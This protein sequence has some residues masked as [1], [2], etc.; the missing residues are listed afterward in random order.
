MIITLSPAKLQD[1]SKPASIKESSKAL[2]PKE[3]EELISELKVFSANEIAELMSISPKQSMEVYQH[4]QGFDMPRT[5]Q[6]QAA[7]AYNG[8]AYKGLDA[9]TIS[10]EDWKFGQEHLIILTGLYGALRPLDLI[11]PYRLEFIIKLANSRGSNLYEFWGDTLTKYFSERLKKDDNTWLN[12]ASHEYSKAINKKD[13]PKG[14]KIVNAIFKE[15]T[16]QGPKMKVV[17]AKKARG[18]MARFVIQNKI[19]KIED[20]KHFDTEGYSFSPSLSTDEDWVF[21]R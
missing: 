17:Y 1:F 15:Q 10:A 6:K 11:K 2:Y 7:F 13:L 14:T 19:T 9:E 3:T 20:I 21:T 16:A 8:I 12:V 18:M 4:I 5:P